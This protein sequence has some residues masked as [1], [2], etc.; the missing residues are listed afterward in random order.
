MRNKFAAE[1]TERPNYFRSV[2]PKNADRS[3]F[4]HREINQVLNEQGKGGGTLL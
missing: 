2:Y 3:V 1:R 4:G